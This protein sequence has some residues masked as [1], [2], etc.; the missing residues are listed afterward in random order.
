MDNIVIVGSSGHSKVVLDI[1]N[2]LGKYNVVGFIDKFRKVG[3]STNNIDVI[4]SEDDLPKLIQQ[5]NVKGCFV[6][7]GDNFTRKKVV[8]NIKAISPDLNFI[9]AIHPNAVISEFVEIGEGSVV[10]AGAV[11]NASANIGKFC[12]INTNSSVDHDCNIL[13][14][15]SLSPNVALG[16]SCIINE[17][18][19]VGIGA[20][21]IHN[22]RIG[23]NS[24]IGAGALV[25]NDIGNN[26]VCYGSPAKIIRTRSDDQKYL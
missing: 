3:E 1:I 23:R 5:Y 22:I 18:S 16:G 24:V 14:F 17:A 6:A 10:M 15:V 19:S 13:D 7:I 25:L 21:V 8:E 9:N 20:T 26:V 4:G 2:K 12:I 11:I